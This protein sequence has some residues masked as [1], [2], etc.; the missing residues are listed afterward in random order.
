MTLIA[1]R[2]FL[3]TLA[4]FLGAAIVQGQTSA[5]LRLQATWKFPADLRGHFD[6]F[7]VDLDGHRLFATPE[8]Y[9]SVVVFDTRTGEIVHIVKG[10]KRPHAILLRG[11][12]HRLYVTDGEAAELKVFDSNDYAPIQTIKLLED[13]DGITYDPGSKLLYIVNGG[14][15]VHTAAHL[16]V[17]D[18][19][20][21][22]KVGDISLG[23]DTLEAMAIDASSG[24]VYI[25]SRDKIQIDVVSLTTR[26]LVSEWKI[27]GANH[28]VAMALDEK[29]HRLFSGCRSGSIVVF[30]T[31]SGKQ[32]Q[33]MPISKGVD[34]LIY[35]PSKKRLY[36]ACDGDVGVYEQTDPDHYS[37]LGKIPSGP[38]AKTAILV[39]ELGKLF[40]ALPQHGET[41]AEVLVFTIQ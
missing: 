15:D 30:D 5:P 40:V 38:T 36:A 20:S 29:D 14:V 28:C 17:V 11:D 26:T 6:H 37:L 16:T 27:A 3:F 10:I 9:A 35:D 41:S 24:K 34:D 12:I 7:A 4:I 13:A 1:Q 18:T 32:L 33:A 2:R 22:S 19:T 25:N 21:V 8:D 31:T 23:D 39:P